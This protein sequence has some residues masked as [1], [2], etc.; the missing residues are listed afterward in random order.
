MEN[1]PDFQAGHLFL[2][3][4]PLQWTSFDVV[5]KLR[6]SLKR[7]L[8]L[9]KFKVGHAGTLDPLATGLLL[10][11]CG[12]KTK[13]IND[14]MRLEKTYTG[15]I[16]LGATTPSYDLETSIENVVP[17]LLTNEQIISACTHFVG[18]L[19]QTPPIF[20][21]KKIDGKKAYE[22]ARKGQ[23][24]VMK[25]SNISISSFSI[26]SIQKSKHL[27]TGLD[28][29]FEVS[30]SKGTYIR[31]LA[32]DFGNKL[33]VGGFLSALRRTQIGEHS[34]ANSLSVEDALA[35]IEG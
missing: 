8:G 32:F 19:E 29:E 21:A 18:E 31:S 25:K 5:N 12:K 24:I 2:L 23:E 17:V 35:L 33:G 22:A 26:T 7:K 13:D 6:Y 14:L 3:D 15:T 1:Q 30:C 20:S 16:T 27:E 34:V 11:C 28:C 4:K 10:I 9:K